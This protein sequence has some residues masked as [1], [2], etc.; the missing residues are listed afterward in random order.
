MSLVKVRKEAAKGTYP[1][2]LASYIYTGVLFRAGDSFIR[3]LAQNVSSWA[4]PPLTNPSLHG[5]LWPLF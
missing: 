2:N 3:I 1:A 4:L 5:L